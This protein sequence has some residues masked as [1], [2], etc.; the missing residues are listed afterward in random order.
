MI[1]A[2]MFLRVDAIDVDREFVYVKSRLSLSLLPRP[3][4]N[5]HKIRYTQL[6]YRRMWPA[7]PLVSPISFM[8]L[9]VRA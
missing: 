5:L 2:D 9:H 1:R 8:R 6:H 7:F 4:I 3:L